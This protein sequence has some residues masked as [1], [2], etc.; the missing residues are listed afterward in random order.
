MNRFFIAGFGSEL[1]KVGVSSEAAIRAIGGRAFRGMKAQL[2]HLGYPERVDP[3]GWFVDL[4]R[5]DWRRRFLPLEGYGLA[6]D[7]PTRKEHRQMLLKWVKERFVRAT[8]AKDIS[9][10][11]YLT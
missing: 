5:Q 1:A 10:Q 11:S 2:E 3:L 9:T 4:A 8:S 7:I 6:S